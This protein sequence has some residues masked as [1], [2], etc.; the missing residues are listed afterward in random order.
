MF[1]TA[2]DQSQESRATP[3]TVQVRCGFC[4]SVN[5]IDMA[6]AADRPRC[7]SC[8]RPILVDRPVRVAEADFQRTV[9]ES[10]APVL[11][12]FYA[13]WCGPCKILA[14]KLDEL[15]AAQT[16]RMLFAKVD[17]D[18]A[19]GVAARYQIRSVP[20]VVLFQNGVETGRSVGI[21]MDEIAGLIRS[22]VGE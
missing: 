15:A 6:R 3:A 17:T 1:K 10:N 16:G 19:Q 11:V 18:Q 22:A 13:D 5:R 4:L 2:T 9:L 8:E 7:G 21:M 20:T 14:P 12:D